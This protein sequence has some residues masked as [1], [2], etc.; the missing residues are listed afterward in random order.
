VNPESPR[1]R[2]LLALVWRHPW[3]TAV[4]IV[5]VCFVLLNFLAYQHARAM[6]IYDADTKRT[7]PPQSLSFGQK[8]KVL[9]CG[10]ANP[11]PSNRRSPQD[12]GLSSQT[13]HIWTADGLN[14][15]AWLLL[16][17][18]PRG[19]V[20]LFHG[21][22]GCRSNLLEQGRTLHQMGFAAL[23]IDF[24][25]SGGSDGC[26]TTVGYREAQDVAAAIQHVR[27]LGLP[28]PL[29][30]YG[31]SMGGAAVLRS[32]SALCVKPDAIIL[33]SVFD[34]LLGTVR[35]RFRL[36]GIPSFPAA[37]LLVFWGGVQMGFSGFDHN[38]VEYA[39]YSNCAALVLH[40]AEDQHAKLD[41]GLAIY[42]RLTGKKEIVVFAG[43]GHISLHEADREQWTAVVGRFLTK[44]IENASRPEL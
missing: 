42:E 30:L 16:P 18:K 22:A 11:R 29:V 25:G 8:A 1:W 35:N 21:Y 12:L 34:R 9:V 31:Q 17:P 43:A 41:E 14:L 24:R 37:E 33:E 38:P 3:R 23:L 15:E 19:T 39:R 5:L 2:R 6:L 26:T 40:G 13:L 10:I 7:P 27:N 32:I 28:R 20:L 4:S 44:Q 36:M